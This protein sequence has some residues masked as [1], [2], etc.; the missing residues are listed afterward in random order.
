M[1]CPTQCAHLQLSQL[2]GEEVQAHVGDR[3]RGVHQAVR[4]AVAHLACRPCDSVPWGTWGAHKA[5]IRPLTPLRS[6]PLP[7]FPF[8]PG[9]CSTTIPPHSYEKAQKTLAAFEADIARYK[10]LQ[11]EVQVGASRMLG[12]HSFG[13]PEVQRASY[14]HG[15]SSM[16]TLFDSGVYPS[17]P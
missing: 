5:P 6:A 1:T 13:V 12:C 7:T 4:G 14:C 11:D 8:S 16:P 3:Q 9:P 15:L 2:L 10:Q 17:S